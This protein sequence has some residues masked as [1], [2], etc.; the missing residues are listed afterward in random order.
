[1]SKLFKSKE[2]EWK[3]R[4]CINTQMCNK[5]CQIF[6]KY[7]AIAWKLSLTFLKSVRKVISM[8]LYWRLNNTKFIFRVWKSCSSHI[9]VKLAISG[10][11]S[12]L[13]VSVFRS[14]L[15]FKAIY[16]NKTL[17]SFLLLSFQVIPDYMSYSYGMRWSLVK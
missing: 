7:I 17:I 6:L 14:N 16:S 13:L 5:N 15:H 12:L 9:L 2:I 3:F 1:M 8:K 4:K 11:L 10:F